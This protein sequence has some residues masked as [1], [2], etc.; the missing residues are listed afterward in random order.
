MNLEPLAHITETGD[1]HPLPEH[2][3][4]VGEGSGRNAAPFGGQA[5]GR[6]AGRWHD[7]GKYRRGFQLYVRQVNGMDAHIEG[8][9]GGREKTHS[10]AGALWAIQTLGEKHGPRGALAARVLAYLIASHHAGLYDWDGGLDARLNAEDSRTELAEA[11]AANPPADI[12]DTGDFVPD[13]RDIS[14]GSAGFALWVRMLFSCLVDADFLDTEAFFDAGKPQAR[15]GFPA[16][17]QMLAVFDGHMETV[18]ENVLPYS[19]DTGPSCS[20]WCHFRHQKSACCSHSQA[21][22]LSTTRGNRCAT[23]LMRDH[24]GIQR[25]PESIRLWLQA[26]ARLEVPIPAEC[27]VLA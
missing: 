2:L 5:W 9:V 13:L 11:L 22:R 1:E 6:M 23:S 19:Q 16:I 10:A 21:S 25:Q 3:F 18:G 12:L 26:C 8:K 27:S 15:S 4:Q 24:D 20:R 7:L 17:A 14:G